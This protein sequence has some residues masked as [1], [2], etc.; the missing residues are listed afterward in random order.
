MDVFA[1][2]RPVHRVSD[3]VGQPHFSN[4]TPIDIPPSGGYVPCETIAT[5][6]FA[7]VYNFHHQSYLAE[8]SPTVFV[9]GKSVGHQGAIYVCS[10]SVTERGDMSEPTVFVPNST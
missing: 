7:A 8:G 4:A 5:L 9:N 6:G 10:A 2:S 1:D 3:I